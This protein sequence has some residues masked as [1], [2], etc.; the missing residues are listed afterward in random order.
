[1]DVKHVSGPIAVA[2]SYVIADAAERRRADLRRRKAATKAKFPKLGP[3]GA[4]RRD[5]RHFFTPFDL[6][7]YGFNPIVPVPGAKGETWRSAR[8]AATGSCSA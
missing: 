6:M 7:V 1:M 5:R 8:R 2:A 3:R 4:P